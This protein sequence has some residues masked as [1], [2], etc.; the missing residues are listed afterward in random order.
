MFE[1]TNQSYNLIIYRSNTTCWPLARSPTA[2][3]SKNSRCP[4][5][6][7]RDA[8]APWAA[9][10]WYFQ[11]HEIVAG[12]WLLLTPLKNDGVKVSWDDDIPN[13]WKNMFQ[14]TNQIPMSNVGC[15]KSPWRLK[16]S[17]FVGKS[18]WAES[19]TWL[20]TCSTGLF[21]ANPIIAC[22]DPF[23]IG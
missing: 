2:D 5:V 7:W 15:S 6:I 16:P 9:S 23:S 8:P 12:W 1:T 13:I 17:F 21:I 20:Q 14:T 19:N 11:R 10:A 18:S 22:T 3:L 4:V